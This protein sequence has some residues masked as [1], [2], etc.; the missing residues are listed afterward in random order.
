MTSCSHSIE[1][2]VRSE[3]PSFASSCACAVASYTCNAA[4]WRIVRHEGAIH[5]CRLCFLRD[6]CCTGSLAGT[7]IGKGAHPAEE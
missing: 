4:P 5:A 3:G 7:T 6:L 1:V 2:V